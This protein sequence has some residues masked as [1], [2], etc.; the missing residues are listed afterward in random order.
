MTH[1]TQ[2]FGG[3]L[4][5]AAIVSS[6]GAASAVVVIGVLSAWVVLKRDTTPM[7]LELLNVREP[8]AVTAPVPAQESDSLLEQAEIAFAAG[9]IIEPEFDNA[10]SYYNQLLRHEPDNIEA[11]EGVE[12]VVT[13]LL[14]QAEG[15]IFQNDWDAARAYARVILGV[16]PQD[17]HATDIAERAIRLEQIELLTATALDQFSAGKLVAPGDDS[18]AASYQAILALEPDNRVAKQG[19]K[20]VV[21]RLVANAQ[22]AALAG[23]A[24]R[25]EGF[26]AEAR[27]LDSQAVG[28]SEIAQSTRQWQQ[29]V[30]DRSVKNDLL[31]AAQALREGRLMAP[32]T[33]NAYQLF[34]EVLAREPASE[35]ARQGL[36][37]VREALLD[38]AEARIGSGDLDA[39]FE[40]VA[41]AAKADADEEGLR[42]LREQLAYK[43][44]LANAKS[45]QFDQVY[46]VS[47]LTVVKQVSPTYPRLAAR[48]SLEGWVEVEFTVTE[49]GEVRDAKV[50]RSSSE[51][52]D[53][54]ALAA[55]NRW[56]FA[57]LMENGRPVPIRVALRFAFDGG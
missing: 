56:E 34:N 6:L 33:P 47:D 8:I 1:S 52:F 57:P 20:A 53:K 28:L 50:R 43:M 40:A 37:L 15:A 36:A 30:D 16:R 41:L 27:A 13:Y 38:Q 55:I 14:N 4:P 39:A 32:D 25:A 54:S 42:R 21:Q 31:A 22:S 23:D 48:R 17:A 10:L 18:A 46:Q 5:G 19:I 24:D 29:I 49:R 9:R 51:L 44:R 7:G 26:L 11:R 12:R 45:G 35:S 2:L 3:Q